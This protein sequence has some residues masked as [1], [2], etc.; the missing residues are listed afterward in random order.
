MMRR[1]A[2]VVPPN[3]VVWEVKT[4]TRDDFGNPGN[5]WHDVT[6][7]PE[8]EVGWLFDG[9]TFTP[10]PRPTPRPT[11][12]EPPDIY[13]LQRQVDALTTAVARLEGR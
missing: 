3:P 7:R 4:I 13:E 12:P 11:P 1:L 2:L 10:P 8:V 9:Q 5:V 6:D